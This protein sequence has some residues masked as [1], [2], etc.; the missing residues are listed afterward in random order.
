MPWYGMPPLQA[1]SWWSQST[2]CCG[3]SSSRE[4]PA[5]ALA[6]SID[7]VAEK[8]Q[9]EPHWPWSFTGVTTPL[10]R[11]SRLDARAPRTD[12][13]S[14]G[15]SMTGSSGIFEASRFCIVNMRRNSSGSISRNGL[16]P[17]TSS[18]PTA[19][20]AALRSWARAQLRAKISLRVSCSSAPYPFSYFTLN[21]SHMESTSVDSAWAPT[22]RA[23][24]ARESAARRAIVQSGMLRRGFRRRQ[25]TERFTRNT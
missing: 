9:Q 15:C 16:M 22:A 5:I 21:S 11:Q 10:S 17:C 18:P 3:A 20:S 6:L 2:I 23:K 12:G 1:L 7:S 4:W 24:T 19:S 25:C 14:A 8:A 13:G